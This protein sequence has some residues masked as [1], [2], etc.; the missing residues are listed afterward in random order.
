MAQTEAYLVAQMREL[1]GAKQ[2]RS[3]KLLVCERLSA[4][5]LVLLVTDN[6]VAQIYRERCL[7]SQ[8]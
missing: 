7:T 4:F 8:E 3:A 5:L 1:N 2:F 6:G